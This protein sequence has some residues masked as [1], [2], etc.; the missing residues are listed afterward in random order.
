MVVHSTNQEIYKYIYSQV[1]HLGIQE[2]Q[3][4]VLFVDQ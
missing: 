2:I 3:E 4:S 1:V